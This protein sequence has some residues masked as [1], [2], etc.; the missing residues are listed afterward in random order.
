MGLESSV[1]VT[2]FRSVSSN[3]ILLLSCVLNPAGL[4]WI[5]WNSVEE[6]QQGT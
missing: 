3:K 5:K 2:F 1:F 6:D 4:Q